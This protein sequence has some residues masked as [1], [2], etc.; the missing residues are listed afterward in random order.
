MSLIHNSALKYAYKLNRDAIR[1]SA[2]RIVLMQ[3]TRLTLEK[4]KRKLP[5]FLF[6][7]WRSCRK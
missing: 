6:V 7:D 2:P 1:P 4:I 3:A 5:D